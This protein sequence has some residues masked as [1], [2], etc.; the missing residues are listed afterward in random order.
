MSISQGLEIR[1]GDP[2]RCQG[3]SSALNAAVLLARFLNLFAAGDFDEMRLLFSSDAT[4]RIADREGHGPF[5][6]GRSALLRNLQTIRQHMNGTVRIRSDIIANCCDTA[7]CTWDLVNEDS[8][9]TPYHNSGTLT[10]QVAHG[11]I[12]A[13]EEILDLNVL[14]TLVGDLNSSI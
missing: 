13:V 7:I 8:N 1:D 6:R 14:T 9:G 5:W 11:V 10:A 2:V 3:G 4:Y 12:V